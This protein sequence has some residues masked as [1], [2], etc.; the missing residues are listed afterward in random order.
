RWRV[1]EPPER[2]RL[3]G[4]EATCLIVELDEWLHGDAHSLRLHLVRPDAGDPSID[5]KRRR[6]PRRL[7]IDRRVAL[8]VDDVRAVL[9]AEQR[10]IERRQQADPITRPFRLQS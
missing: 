8:V 2:I 7:S 1:E 4:D 3:A 5:K 6:D 9:M 10:E